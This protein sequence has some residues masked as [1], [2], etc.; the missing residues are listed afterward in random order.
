MTWL[1]LRNRLLRRQWTLLLLAS[2]LLL[3]SPIGAAQDGSGPKAILQAAVRSFRPGEPVHL[4]FHVEQDGETL[5]DYDV[6]HDKLCHLMLVS[7]DYTD[8]QHIHPTLDSTGK[9]NI[10]DVVFRRPGRYYVF[11]DVTPQ[12][13]RQLVQRFEVQVEGRGQPL[14]LQEDLRDRGAAGVRIRLVSQPKFIRT[15]DALLRFQLTRN[16][17]PVR[18]LKPLMS[19]LGHVVALGKDGKPF[20]HIHPFDP[21]DPIHADSANSSNTTSNPDDE[22]CIPRAKDIVVGPGE[23]VFHATFP[24]AGFYQVWGQFLV[25]EQQ[26]VAP[27]TVRVQ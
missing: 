1:P 16:D 3:P 8:F 19:A 2:L 23:V 27:F 11:L 20:L 14:Q 10:R 26:I 6:V 24:R 4:T 25:G 9:F 22:M 21:N 12:G 7:A 17:Q 13:S 18:D 15:G 5:T